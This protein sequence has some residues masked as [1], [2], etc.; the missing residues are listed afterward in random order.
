MTKGKGNSVRE[1]V[2]EKE[3][4]PNV[5]GR[6]GKRD[7]QNQSGSIQL[8]WYRLRGAERSRPLP[9]LEDPA[10]TGRSGS[11]IGVPRW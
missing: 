8:P 3:G 4:V 7:P 10:L 2:P 5:V 11:L 6:S 9:S 1:R